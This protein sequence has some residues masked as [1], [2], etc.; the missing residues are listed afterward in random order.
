LTDARE[1]IE[2]TRVPRAASMVSLYNDSV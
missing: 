2:L 1:T